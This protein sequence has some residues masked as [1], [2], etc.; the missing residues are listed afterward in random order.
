MHARQPLVAL[1]SDVWSAAFKRALHRLLALCAVAPAA[2]DAARQRAARRRARAQRGHAAGVAARRGGRRSRRSARRCAD[3]SAGI[4]TIGEAAERLGLADP[5]VATAPNGGAR[6]PAEGAQL[7]ATCGAESA[8]RLLCYA[9]VAWLS[10]EMLTVDLGPRTTALQLAA[11]QR[12]FRVDTPERAADARHACVR[13]HRVQARG[14]RARDGAEQ[15]RLQRDRFACHSNPNH[16]PRAAHTRA[17]R[18]QASPRARSRPSACRARAHRGCTARSARRPRCARRS[19][20][21]PR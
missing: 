10:E 5:P 19:R 15:H 2:R 13:V 11:L 18:A 9:R 16:D 4:L 7:L 6:S 1:A 12:R 14:Q 8:A 17:C 20:S 3:P 21:S